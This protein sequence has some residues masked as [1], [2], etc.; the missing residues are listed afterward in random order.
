[1]KAAQTEVDEERVARENAVIETREAERR[2][3]ASAL[4]VCALS[5]HGSS[6]G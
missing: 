2:L 1:L 4:K 6:R 3:H 5:K